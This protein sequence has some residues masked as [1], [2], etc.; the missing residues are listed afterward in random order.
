MSRI[1]VLPEDMLAA[2]MEVSVT[3]G[4]IFERMQLPLRIWFAAM[5]FVTSR[6]M[7]FREELDIN[8]NLTI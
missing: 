8:Q 2:T 3:A 5:L 7:I 6:K 1:N 4:T